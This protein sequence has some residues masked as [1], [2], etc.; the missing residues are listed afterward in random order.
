MKITPLQNYIVTKVSDDNDKTASGFIVKSGLEEPSTRGTVLSAGPL[1][2]DIK[3][4]DIIMFKS[5]APE[6]FSIDGET[7]LLLTDKDVIATISLT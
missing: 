3:A 7:V 5:Y 2:K 1:V 6:S 4:E